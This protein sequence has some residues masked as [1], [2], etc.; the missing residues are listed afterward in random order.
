M[1]EIIHE[2]KG[3]TIKKND[4]NK[5]V[6]VTLFFYA[7]PLKA[8]P[9]WIEAASIGMSKADVQKEY[10]IDYT[11]LQGERVFPQMAL[12]KDKI[13]LDHKTYPPPESITRYWAG[14]DYG[15]RNPSSFIVFGEGKNTAGEP[16]VFALWEHY[17]PT[18]NLAN[19]CDTM[20]ECEYYDKISWISCDPSIFW[21]NQQTQFGLTSIADQMYDNGI[22]LLVPGRKEEDSF[23]TYVH[24]CWADL[25]TSLSRFYILNKCPNLIREF[26]NIVYATQSDQSLKNSSPK[27]QMV[28]KDNHALDAAKYFFNSYHGLPKQVKIDQTTRLSEL[29]DIPLWKRHIK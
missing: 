27:E 24:T 2:Q 10:Y 8:D 5:V 20:K 1:P 28:N 9:R 23:I 4:K 18:K 29:K 25:D 21:K 16:S 11:A 19:L 12:H 15:T 26:E 14:F 22:K 3:L 17:E 13:V 6:V 7:D